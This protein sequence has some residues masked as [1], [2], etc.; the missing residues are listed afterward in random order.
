MLNQQVM[1]EEMAQGWMEL[2]PRI[3]ETYTKQLL[4]TLEEDKYMSCLSHYVVQEDQHIPVYQTVP[5]N[6][7]ARDMN[8]P[9]TPNPMLQVQWTT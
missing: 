5:I 2:D 8:E 4:T 6:A 7:K 3:T 1:V 9:K